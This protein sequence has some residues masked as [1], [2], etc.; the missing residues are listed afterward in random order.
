MLPRH[1]CSASGYETYS[2]GFSS[3]KSAILALSGTRF[4]PKVISLCIIASLSHKKE[5]S[6]MGKLSRKKKS[7]EETAELDILAD[8]IEDEIIDLVDP[9][10]ET[11]PALDDVSAD[12]NL[13]TIETN[14][15][16]FL[17]EGEEL[18]DTL[19]EELMG[20]NV[21]DS[22]GTLTHENDADLD[23]EKSLV[24]MF[25]TTELLAAELVEKSS[26][27]KKEGEE[28]LTV[29]EDPSDDG[30]VN[31]GPAAKATAETTGTGEVLESEDELPENIFVSLELVKEAPG[32]KDGAT[33]VDT[34]PGATSDKTNWIGSSR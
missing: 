28:S 6:S 19:D 29:G 23:F 3:L 21:G 27:T 33:A 26:Q 8:T 18:D 11:A 20:V 9:V 32:K 25:E 13:E 10:E 34:A 22:N 2:V 24:K 31:L 7:V 16:L 4:A 17:V 30:N 14:L 12:E 5:S 15:D 1:Y